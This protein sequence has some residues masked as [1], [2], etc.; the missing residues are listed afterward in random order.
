MENTNELDTMRAQVALLRK[1]LE[2]EQMISEKLLRS[3]IH[4]KIGILTR[5]RV[6]MIVLTLFVMPFTLFFSG[7]FDGFPLAFT[8]TIELFM[9]IGTIFTFYSQRGIS[10]YAVAYDRLVDTGNKLIRLNRLN[11]RWLRFGI[12]TVSAILIWMAWILVDDYQEGS[13]LMPALI[14][15]IVGF[16]FGMA[17]GIIRYR[18]R[19]R[20]L[21]ELVAQIEEL[22]GEHIG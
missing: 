17:I 2:S 9:I 20:D 8:I 6:L 13:P 11:A 18:K 15:G 14:G 4:K 16:V 5:E 3:V 10:D 1:K 7:A 21:K 19:R 22:T 12:P